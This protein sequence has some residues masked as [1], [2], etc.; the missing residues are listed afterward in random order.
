MTSKCKSAIFMSIAMLSA[1]STTS[2]AHAQSPATPTTAYTPDPIT[3]TRQPLAGRLFFSDDDRSKLNRIRKDGALPLEVTDSQTIERA[4]APVLNG[5]VKRSDGVATYWVNGGNT[6]GTRY[7][8]G[9][10]VDAGV[11][12]TSS[13]VGG[14][15]RVL[16]SGMTVG[17]PKIKD[18]PMEKKAKN[19]PKKA[20]IK[21]SRVNEKERALKRNRTTTKA[22]K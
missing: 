5:F 22:P 20:Q 13:M 16:L 7:A 18:K 6:S 19:P 8:V 11:T 2:V 21:K 15:P 9:Q 17:E 12:A 3:N 1:I 10:G 4:S 14:E